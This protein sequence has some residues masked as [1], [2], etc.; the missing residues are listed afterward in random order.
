MSQSKKHSLIEA[1]TNTAVG[2]GISLLSISI[3]LPLMGFETS[4]E[5]N[6]AL[7]I[8]F[9]FISIGRSY[10]LRRIFNKKTKKL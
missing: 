8:Y 9:T 1:V 6:I 7:T 2:F 10:I 4:I 3:I 5:Q